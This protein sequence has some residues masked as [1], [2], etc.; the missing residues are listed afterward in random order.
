[1]AGVSVVPVR[2]PTLP[3]ATHTNAYVLGEHRV[4]IVDPASPW[5]DQQALLAGALAGL[6]VERIL[7]TH[8]HIDHS[9]GAEDL[10][11]RTGAPIYAHPDTAARLSFPID[12]L[13]GDGDLVETDAGRWRVLHT[14]GH[15]AGHLALHDAASGA[16]VAGDLVAGEGTIVLDP[17]EGHLATYLASLARVAALQPTTVLPAHGPPLGPEVL[18]TYTAHRHARTEQI[19]V[20]LRTHGEAAPE[21]LV[22]AVYPSLHPF[23]AP[24][25]ARQLLCH[26]VWLVEQGEVTEG[27]QGRFLT[28]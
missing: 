27:S 11:R 8:H 23:L 16:V 28:R 24:V 25:A 19:R 3:P 15:A 1:M 13:L 5:E 14:P 18:A 10:R 7:L 26:L 4:T 9:S 17:P 12:I 21:D 6:Q 2:T 22:P 20:A